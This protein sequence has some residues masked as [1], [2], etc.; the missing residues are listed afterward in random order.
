MVYY[1]MRKLQLIG[2]LLFEEGLVDAR[3]GN[4]SVRIGDKMLITRRG[5]FLG[6]L[7]DHD[8]ILL[9]IKRE[10]LLDERASSE[11][12][13]HREVYL[14]T[15]K[16]A[17][18]HAHPVSAVKLSFEKDLIVPKDSEG[19]ELL[20]SVR[21]LKE[22]PSG[23]YQLAQAVAETLA[24]EKLVV[25]RGHGVFSADTDVFYAYSH[26]SVL[27]HSCKILLDE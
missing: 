24:G 21:V 7:K 3:A 19:K 23:S 6:D 4:L 16:R 13:V 5:S 10:S 1:Q 14:K 26:I 8:F 11:L 18:V 22:L 25:V 9:D 2:R 15:Q 20:G 12:V 17:V 27:E